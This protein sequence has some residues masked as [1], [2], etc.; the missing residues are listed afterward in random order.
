MKSKTVDLYRDFG[1]FKY[2]LKKYKL[3]GGTIGGFSA[4]NGFSKNTF[5]IS[6]QYHGIP[7]HAQFALAKEIEIYNLMESLKGNACNRI[8]EDMIYLDYQEYITIH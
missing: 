2:I 1:F 7:K 6:W 5:S 8:S 4:N 3:C